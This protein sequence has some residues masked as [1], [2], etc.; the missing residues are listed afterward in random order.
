MLYRVHVR[1]KTCWYSFVAS[2]FDTRCTDNVCHM[3]LV[4]LSRVDGSPNVI[5]IPPVPARITVG[6]REYKQASCRT[7]TRCQMPVHAA[8]FVLVYFSVLQIYTTY[9]MYLGYIP[10]CTSWYV[11]YIFRPFFMSLLFLYIHT[12]MIQSPWY[13]NININLHY[14]D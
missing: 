10:L 6:D 9:S 11:S 1:R 13:I 2:H 5:N 12:Y 7:S 3:I 14:L 8:L 4:R